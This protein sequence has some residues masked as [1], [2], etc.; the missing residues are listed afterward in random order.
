MNQFI[1]KTHAQMQEAIAREE[2]KI[3]FQTHVNDDCIQIEPYKTQFYYMYANLTNTRTYAKDV[4]E[5]AKKV[6]LDAEKEHY[7]NSLKEN[8][9]FNLLIFIIALLVALVAFLGIIPQISH[10]FFYMLS[11][12]VIIFSF[13]PLFEYYRLIGCKKKL[14]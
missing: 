5:Q 12:S 2:A 4:L 10:F 14:N 9:N 11:S 8:C 13:I 6:L 7:E 1:Q 3:F